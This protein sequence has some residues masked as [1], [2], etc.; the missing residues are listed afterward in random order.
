MGQLRLSGT[1]RVHDADLERLNAA[2]SKWFSS[3]AHE[4]NPG[5]IRGPGRGPLLFGVV[6]QARR[7][8]RPVR[9]DHVNLGSDVIVG[10]VGEGVARE[11][12][13]LP[14][15]RPVGVIVDRRRIVCDVLW[16]RPL[17][18]KVV[19][20]HDEDIASRGRRAR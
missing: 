16:P 4:H 7:L 2:Y 6:G 14:L 12:D 5:A 13:L 18:E 11:N 8:A 3:S 10:I 15:G 20:V 17:L 1:V 19:Y 9:V